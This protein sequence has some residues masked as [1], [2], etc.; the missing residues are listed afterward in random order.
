MAETT[1]LMEEKR[2]EGRKEGREK[3]GQRPGYDLQR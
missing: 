3:K 1:G 2:E